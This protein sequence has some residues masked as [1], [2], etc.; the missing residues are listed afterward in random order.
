MATVS[1]RI[2]GSLAVAAIF[3]PLLP[4]AASA[5]EP[6]V[7][8]PV[9]AQ[10]VVA[11]PLVAQPVAPSAPAV[12]PNAWEKAPAT[13]RSGFVVGAALG[14]GL[15][16]IVG[17]PNDAKKIGFAPYYTATGA[18]PAPA[19]EL[20]IGGALT[21]WF[22]FGLGFTGGSLLLTGD[23][24]A[25]ATAGLFHVEAFPLFYVSEKLRDLGVMLDVGTG[26]AS[27]KSKT[28]VKLV[29][30]SSA[31]LVGGGVFWEPA[32]LWRFRGGPFL[33]GNYIW[34]DTARRPGVFAGW[35]MSL[36]TGP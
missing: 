28:D 20:W 27:V 6:L 12:D 13:R 17:F 8:H 11:Q 15:A 9:V 19:F 18:R 5:D 2:L 32:R 33:M 16:S 35:R 21:D 10:P 30:S 26:N 23:T 29:D 14:G 4:R 7:A 31:S 3:A 34:S 24:K 36:Y 1:P 22:T 25:T